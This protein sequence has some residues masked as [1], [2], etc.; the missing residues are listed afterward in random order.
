MAYDSMG[1]HCA[2]FSTRDGVFT[3]ARVVGRL[4]NHTEFDLGPRDRMPGFLPPS[5]RF[6]KHVAG[7][8]KQGWAS[9][10]YNL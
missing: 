9:E 6:S 10:S 2:A 1:V 8:Y 5:G 3:R 4:R 7:A